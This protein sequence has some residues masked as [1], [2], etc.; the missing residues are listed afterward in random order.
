MALRTKQVRML[1]LQVPQ[2]SVHE[3]RLAVCP[4]EFG[5]NSFCSHF[6]PAV[7]A[8]SLDFPVVGLNFTAVSHN[9]SLLGLLR[10]LIGQDC[11]SSGPEMVRRQHILCRSQTN[12]GI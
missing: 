4:S 10:L 6:W 1:R 8:V 5:S 2:I 3:R 11:L 12:G 9:P 7:T